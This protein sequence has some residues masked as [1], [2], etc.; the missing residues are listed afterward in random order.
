MERLREGYTLVVWKLDRM[1]RSL[2]HLVNLVEDLQNMRINFV[3]L[4]ENIDTGN[5]QGRLFFNIMASL[6]EFERE[7]IRERT[8]S[9]LEAAKQRGGFGG[10]P[11]ITMPCAF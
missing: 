10:R 1:G 4:N 11:R 5:P 3:S 2:K 7:I 6:A 9:G 8:K